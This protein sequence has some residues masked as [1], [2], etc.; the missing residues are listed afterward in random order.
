MKVLKIIS[1]RK[2]TLGLEYKAVD[3]KSSDVVGS[4]VLEI[5]MQQYDEKEIKRNL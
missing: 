2:I 5:I 1:F 4:I 3:I